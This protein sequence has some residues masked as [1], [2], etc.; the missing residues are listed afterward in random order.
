[1]KYIILI[2]ASLWFAICPMVAEA[3]NFSYEQY[4]MS[5]LTMNSG[6]PHNSVNDVYADSY[7]FIWIATNGGGL[8]RYDGYSFVNPALGNAIGKPVSNS[9]RN[10]VEDNF[11]RLWIS[12]DECTNVLDL[13]TMRIVFHQIGADIRKILDEPSV[14]TYKDSKGAIWLVTYSMIYY[15][16]FDNEG[17]IKKI[18]KYKYSSNTPDIHIKDVDGNGSVWAAID[19]GLYKLSVKGNKLVRENLMPGLAKIHATYITDFLKHGDIIWIGSNQGLYKYDTHKHSLRHYIRNGNPGSLSHDYV[20]CLV[21]SVDNCLLVGTLRGINIYNETTDKFSYWDIHSAVNP[22]NSNFVHSILYWN[23]LLFIGT[24][25]GGLIKL[26]PRQLILKN[27]VHTGTSQSLSPNPVNSMYTESDGT[28]WVGT[29]EGGLNRK[30]SGA[31]VFSHITSSNSNLSHNSVSTIS[32][33]NKRQLWIGTWGG[34]VNIVDMNNARSVKRLIVDDKYKQLLLFVGTMIYDP[35]N[36]GIWIGSNDGL[37]F[38][39]YKTS[40]LEEPF[41]GCKD[42]RG[43]I[44]SIIDKDGNLWVGC[45]KGVHEVYLKKKRNERFFRQR[46]LVYKLDKPESGV[47]DK[48]TSFCEAKD[49][50]LWLGSNGYGLYKR[51]VDESGKERFKA[52]TAQEGLSNNSVKGIVQDKRG[53]LWIAT[54]NGL[55]ELDPQKH[56]FTNYTIEDGLISSQFYWNAAITDKVGNIYLGSEKGLTVISGG[57]THYIYKGLLCFTRLIVDNQDIL[58]DGNYL[59]KDISIADKIHLREGY[60]SFSIE[61]SALNYGNETQGVY[62]YRMK[63]FEDEWVQ[64]PAGQ[65]SVRYTNLPAGKYTFEVKYS[66]SLVSND[67]IISIGVRVSPYFWKSLWFTTLMV[68]LLIILSIYIYNRRIFELKRKEA[69]NLLRPIEKALEESEDAEL[70]QIR[71][72]NILD[73]QQRYSESFNKSA[74]TDLDELMHKK[75]LMPFM[76]RVMA[77]MEKNYSDSDFDVTGFGSAMEMSKSLL[78]KKLSAEIGISATQFIREYRLRIA[79]ELILKNPGNQNVTDIAYS[80]GFNDPKYFSRCFTKLFG[81]SPSKMKL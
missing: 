28:L 34:G 64:L 77:V 10:L 78:T 71:I 61:F 3:R 4:N 48:I 23:G 9:C 43:C 30:A 35:I 75:H 22:L 49:G 27:Y 8:V 55:S 42:I 15:F 74:E 47:I 11:H 70:L 20:S 7:G 65:H 76:D 59:D 29:V 37:F 40:K 25:T 21:L 38:Y 79:K 50:T 18:L 73:N 31:S 26:S 67:N 81:C 69:E 5:Y 54:S 62:S 52:Y 41:P 80:V 66:S 24:D 58:A 33:D 19:G 2:I 6:L 56:V 63:G 1:M 51:I 36:D 17:N 46:A 68:L 14:R 12:Y 60:K 16:D 72:Q 32:V 57:N 39:N 44:G 13:N 53:M 45:L